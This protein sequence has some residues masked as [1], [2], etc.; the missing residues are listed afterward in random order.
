ML[1]LILSFIPLLALLVWY[2]IYRCKLNKL[3]K[4]EK[5]KREIEDTIKALKGNDSNYVQVY[6]MGYYHNVLKDNINEQITQLNNE[7]DS[8]DMKYKFYNV[9]FCHWCWF[10]ILLPLGVIFTTI[11]ANIHFEWKV[12]EL[13]QERESLIYQAKQL[14]TTTYDLTNNKYRENLIQQIKDYN[15]RVYNATYCKNDFVFG[16]F[17]DVNYSYV[18][19]IDYGELK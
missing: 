17:Y 18:S 5:K 8:I 6:T 12:N 16:I 2:I 15:I 3:N 13:E 10:Y 7:Y 4:A 9:G 11:F 19:Q 14:E 1:F